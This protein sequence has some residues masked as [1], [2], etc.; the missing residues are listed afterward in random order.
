LSSSGVT[1][2]AGGGADSFT[3]TPGTGGCSPPNILSF[4]G[5]V[6]ITPSG[7][8]VAF[9]V[10]PNPFAITRAGVI[11]VANQVFTVT[12]LG[13]A[14]A[15]S[16]NNYGRLFNYAGGS[17]TVLGSPSGLGCTPEVGTDQPSI[18]TL[19]TL[20][21]P[22]LNIFTLPYDVAVLPPPLTPFVRRMN[23]TFGGRVFVV[24]QTSW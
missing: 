13:S 11:Q 1:V 18:I 12:Q 20:T 8:A 4:A 14:C 7:N 21:G 15:Y 24:K 23:I 22:L 5:W 17:S 19:G 6:H 3:F 2:S 10:D 16:L 9:T